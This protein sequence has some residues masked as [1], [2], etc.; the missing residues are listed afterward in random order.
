MIKDEIL[1]QRHKGSP[2]MSALFSILKKDNWIQVIT[3]FCKLNK[4]IKQNTY[5]MPNIQDVMMNRSKYKYFTK[6]D[7]RMCFYCF[8]LTEE[9][10]QL[11]TTMHTNRSL[12]EY[13]CL[14]MGLKCLPDI[15]QSTTE[16]ILHGLDCVIYINNIR[17]WSNRLYLHH[18]AQVMHVLARLHGAGLKTNPL[19]CEWTV[20]QTDFLGYWMTPEHCQPM[21]K[22]HY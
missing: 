15:V 3:D 17:I 9:A 20:E 2:W 1:R 19:K 22:T 12:L 14:P 13:N 4:R 16:K 5:P 8:K 18:L 7:I 10:K 21:K 11:T 6:I